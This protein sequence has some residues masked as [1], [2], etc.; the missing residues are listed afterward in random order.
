[1]ADTETSI[2]K[3]LLPLCKSRKTL[4]LLFRQAWLKKAISES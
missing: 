1:M 4:R 3:E 2:E